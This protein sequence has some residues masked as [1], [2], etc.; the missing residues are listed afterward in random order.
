[1]ELSEVVAAIVLKPLHKALKDGDHIYGIIKGSGV[2]QDGSTNGITAPS[3][4]S[5]KSLQLQVYRECGVDPS[6]VTYVECHGT[7][8]KLGDP[9]EIAALTES[10]RAYTTEKQFCALGSSKTSIGHAL[11]ACGIAG[12]IK[13]LLC[14]ERK[15]IPPSLH[16]KTPNKHIAFSES[17]FYVNTTLRSWEV[18]KLPRRAAINSFG[19][20]GS[21]AHVVLEEF[22]PPV[23]MADEGELVPDAHCAIPISARSEFQLKQY[24]GKMLEY[25]E[26]AS[27]QSEQNASSNSSRDELRK[28]Q[29][30]AY[31]MQTGRIALVHRLV[32]VVRSW[33]ELKIELQ[34]FANGG[35]RGPNT[36]VGNANTPKDNLDLTTA[37]LRPEEL[38]TSDRL[39]SM[40]KSWVLGRDV[41]WTSLYAKAHPRRISLPTYPFAKE[42]YWVPVREPGAD[43]SRVSEAGRTVSA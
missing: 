13:V 17:P 8:T 21:N 25:M 33:Q 24:A 15:Q 40:A 18:P 30:I 11:A 43:Q 41:D 37:T 42:R 6:T 10:F 2:N 39:V 9:I 38:A 20:S 28:L 23:Q 29:Q 26:T 19:I 7:G 22:I 35:S 5:Q 14:L 27:L 1:M 31:T 34:A 12:L 16:F 4:E 3:S 32:M 36:W